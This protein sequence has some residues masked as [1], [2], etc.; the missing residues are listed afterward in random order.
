VRDAV[1]ATSW[2]PMRLRIAA[3]PAP[4][5]TAW[6]GDPESVRAG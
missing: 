2:P 1:D 6:L 4:T 3:R 5:V